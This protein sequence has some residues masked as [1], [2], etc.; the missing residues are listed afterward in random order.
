MLYELTVKAGI[1]VDAVFGDK[2]YFRQAILEILKKSDAKAY[3]PVSHCAY[4]IDENLFSYNKDSDQW[5]CVRGNMTVSKKTMKKVRKDIGEYT[6]HDYTFDKEMCIGCPMREE[7]IK[8]AKGKA[9]KL[10]VGQHASEY[11][12]HSQW[13][14]TEAFIAEYKKR[15][16]I[17]GKNGK[18]KCHHGLDRAYG[19]GIES[20]EVQAKLTAIAVNLKK[21]ANLIINKKAKPDIAGKGIAVPIGEE[22]GTETAKESSVFAVYIVIYAFFD[23]E[24]GFF[25]KI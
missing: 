13:A 19:Y 14:K 18:L 15:A 11:Y 17:E 12:E 22:M 25:S 8:K 6:S 16:C 20:V 7:C 24:F 3:I 2:A 23:F 21:I 5:V 1:D 9:K 4:R 10:T